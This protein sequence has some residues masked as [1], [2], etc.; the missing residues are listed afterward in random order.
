[1]KRQCSPK[2]T[3]TLHASMIEVAR[4]EIKAWHKLPP[5][6]PMII[7]FCFIHRFVTGKTVEESFN[8]HPVQTDYEI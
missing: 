1:M 8:S 7:L 4:K 3:E 2:G 6:L 5:G